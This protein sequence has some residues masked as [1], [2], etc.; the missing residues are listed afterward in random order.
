M[1]WGGEEFLLVLLDTDH[2]GARQAAE[3]F[4][5]LIEHTPFH[6]EIRATASFGA[7]QWRPGESLEV[8]FE[9]A[10]IALYRAKD[11]GRNRVCVAMDGDEGN[12]RR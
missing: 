1:R 9:R 12:Q 6:D 2:N 11:S 3:S 4:R 10:D 5:A 7:A 8:L